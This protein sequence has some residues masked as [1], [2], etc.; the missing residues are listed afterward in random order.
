MT[1]TVVGE[2]GHAKQ[3]G[4]TRGFGGKSCCKVVMAGQC[5]PPKEVRLQFTGLGLTMMHLR[6]ASNGMAWGR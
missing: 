4:C 3:M 2:C 6:I 1:E 5:T